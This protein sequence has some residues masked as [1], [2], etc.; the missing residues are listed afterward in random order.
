MELAFRMFKKKTVFKV[1]YISCERKR[2]YLTD[3]LAFYDF[4]GEG[5]LSVARKRSCHRKWI[6]EYKMGCMSKPTTVG[7]KKRMFTGSLFEIN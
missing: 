5:S 4:T 6:W 7:K 3:S 1:N 2:V